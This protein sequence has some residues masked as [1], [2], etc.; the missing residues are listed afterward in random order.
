MQ[1][2]IDAWRA[3]NRINL[4]LLQALEEEYLADKPAA[5]RGR[6]VGEVYA[7]LHTVR[8]RWLEVRAPKI[9]TTQNTIAK[10]SL[11]KAILSE[12]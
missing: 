5:S 6:S 11:S 7:H 10:G 1:D 4:F 8:L 3:A 2:C 9:Y 12:A